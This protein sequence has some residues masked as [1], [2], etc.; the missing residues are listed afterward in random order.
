MP[1][2]R[3]NNGKNRSNRGNV[4]N[5]TCVNCGRQVPKDKAIKKFQVRDM[6][7]GSSR[8]DIA[9][10]SAFPAGKDF[11][12]PKLYYKMQYCISCGIHNRIVAVRS[13]ENRRLRR[14]NRRVD[15]T[16]SSVDG[17][18]R[19]RRK[20]PKSRHNLSCCLLNP[21]VPARAAAL[22]DRSWHCL[23]VRTI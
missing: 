1:S 11:A 6:I 2:K 3:R 12:V 18:R 8:D 7:D 9:K 13:R 4:G 20:R 10:A 23:F 14:Q 5:I 15:P 21:E 22:S 17:R 16:V 19:E